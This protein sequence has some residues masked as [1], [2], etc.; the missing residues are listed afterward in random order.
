[1]ATQ[2]TS[3][4]EPSLIPSSTSQLSAS[5]V[6]ASFSSSRTSSTNDVATI[7]LTAANPTKTLDSSATV[8]P[9]YDNS[10]AVD[11]NGVAYYV[12][13]GVAYNGTVID[14]ST[15]KRQAVLGYTLLE[16]TDMCDMN[17]ECVGLT[18]GSDG[19]CTQYSYVSGYLPDQAPVAAVPLARAANLPTEIS[20]AATFTNVLSSSFT[21]DVA[22]SQ[23]DVSSISASTGDVVST[24]PP[25]QA[26]T[27][28]GA[29]SA[30]ASTYINVSTELPPPASTGTS[31]FNTSMSS[32][33]TSSQ[34]APTKSASP[35]PVVTIFVTPSTCNAHHSVQFS[36]TITYT[37]VTAGAPS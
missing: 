13:C 12:Q 37:T 2:S 25:A 3:A 14:P 19:R 32:N 10:A 24:V 7:S 31:T 27:R 20:V 5:G 35:P 17:E 18:L 21:L 29:S 30:G 1:M 23:T 28:T 11:E 26:S 22:S 8:C 34:A 4:S 15:Q 36:T 33:L 16:C 9:D 6:L